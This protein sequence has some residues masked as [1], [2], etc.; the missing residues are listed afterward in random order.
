MDS[1]IELGAPFVYNISNAA[2]WIWEKNRAIHPKTKLV[3]MIASNKGWLR[4]HQNRLQWVDK[5]KDKYKSNPHINIILG[6]FFE[7]EGAYDLIIEQ[8]FFCAISP[9]LR[10]KYVAKMK[11]LLAPNGKLIGLLFDRTFEQE[12]PPFGGSK[13][14]YISL[15]ENNFNLKYFDKCYNSFIK[16]KD[17]ELFISLVKKQE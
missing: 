3:S 4:G 1:L 9:T 6:D 7:H 12:G 10:E 14:E 8:T 11:A 15:F 17:N 2:P 16:R 13:S 5:L